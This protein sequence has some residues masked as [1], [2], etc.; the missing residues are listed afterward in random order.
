MLGPFFD[1]DEVAQ[2]LGSPRFVVQRRFPVE[3]EDKTRPCDDY[4]SSRTNQA[5]FIYVSSAALIYS[6]HVIL[7]LHLSFSALSA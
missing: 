5:T 1:L 6:G 3:Q 7:P 4:R 2:A